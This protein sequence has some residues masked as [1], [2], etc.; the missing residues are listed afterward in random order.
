MGQ[1]IMI[2]PI[3][4]IEGH[5]RVSIHVDDAG[6]VEQAYMHVDQF[7]GFERF[8]VGRMFFEMPSITPRIC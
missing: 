3:T 7:R 1:K 4:R 6:K 5:A 2:E 8:S